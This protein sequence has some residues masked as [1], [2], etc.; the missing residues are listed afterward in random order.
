MFLKNLPAP[1]RIISPPFKRGVQGG[2]LFLTLLSLSSCSLFGEESYYHKQQV[3]YSKA[4][5]GP[6]LVVPP[7]LTNSKLKDEYTI[8]PVE[9]AQP[10]IEAPFPPGS[11]LDKSNNANKTVGSVGSSESTNSVETS[12]AAALLGES[13]E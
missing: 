4:K 3:A 2:F 7:P 5:D 1:P 10:S 9:K 13:N 8:P 6:G 11:A 12:N